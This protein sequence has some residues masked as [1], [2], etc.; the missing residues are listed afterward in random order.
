MAGQRGNGQRVAVVTGGAIGIGAA[1]AEE[2]GRRGSYVVTMDPVVTLD[3]SPQAATTEATT[4]Q[5]IV[6]AGGAARSSSTSVTDEDAVRS[7]FDELVEEFGALDVVVNVAGISRSTGF[8][9]GTDE[10]WA[11]VLDVHLNGYLTVLRVALPLMAAAGHGRVLGVTSGSGWR[12]ADAGSYAC[13]KR[14]V[15]ALTWQIGRA[16]PP[17][18]T[19]NALSPIAATRMVANA[20]SRQAGAGDRSG[21]TPASGGVA[22]TA[23]P[24]PEH[25]GP[26]GAYLASDDLA[27]CSGHVLFS[28]GAEISAVT[29]PQL[30]EAV[31]TSGV[32]SVAHV[33]DTAVPTAFAAAEAAQVST[34][35]SIPRLGAA[36]DPAAAGTSTSRAC[37]CAIV[38]HDPASTARLRAALGARGVDV[39]EVPGDAPDIAA[40]GDALATAGADAPLDAVVVALAGMAVVHGG[41]SGAEEGWARILD[42]HAGIADAIRT[43]ARWVR[44][45]ADRSGATQRP[46]RVVTLTDAA[47]AGGRSRAMAAAQ[48]ARAA[49]TATDSRVDA[50]AIAVEAATD[51]AATAAAE[52]AA[53]LVVSEAA[54]SLSGAELV[55]TSDWVGLRSH[56]NVAGT[57]AYGGPEVPEWLD[58]T[59]RRLVTGHEGGAGR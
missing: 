50:F 12:A 26:I 11:R 58:R 36:F 8:A 25:L 16:T 20:L 45:V 22:L 27:W 53:H 30:L 51:T 2:L 39:V 56:P 4:A 13:A 49:H 23:A 52:L 37:R 7:L 54:A 6:A 35:G 43:D 41:P 24:P 59:V 29:S 32:P 1:I 21:K 42:E 40:A 9:S 47:T 46:I 3:G 33:I 38:A 14:A 5:R 44:A 10:D 55:A 17:G 19:V 31:R 18:V 15:A 48:L 57:V 28:N 34:G